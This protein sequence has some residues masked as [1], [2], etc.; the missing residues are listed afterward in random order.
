MTRVKTT[1]HVYFNILYILT[2]ML[3]SLYYVQQGC[4][5]GSGAETFMLLIRCQCKMLRSKEFF[6][7]DLFHFMKKNVFVLFFIYLIYCTG[8]SGS[9]FQ[10]S[11]TSE[12]DPVKN[13]PALNHTVKGYRTTG[14][15][16]TIMNINSA[17]CER[18]PQHLKLFHN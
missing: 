10:I 17:H 14:N 12:R 7:V 2:V 13:E 5:T 11:W 6:V 18:L 4:G 16:S 3:K 9:G 15:Y 8:G 1:V